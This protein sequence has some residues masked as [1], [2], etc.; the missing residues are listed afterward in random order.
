MNRVALSWVGPMRQDPLQG[1]GEEG[2]TEKEVPVAVPREAVSP[3]RRNRGAQRISTKEGLDR[4]TPLQDST[5]V[6]EAVRRRLRATRPC[7]AAPEPPR[8]RG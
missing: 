2:P 4:Q 3:E 8:R 7:R 5:A 6:D 1:T